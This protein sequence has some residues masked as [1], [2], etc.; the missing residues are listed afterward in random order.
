MYV[1]LCKGQEGEGEGE[2]EG[3]KKPE[4]KGRRGEGSGRREGREWSKEEKEGTTE[5][6]RRE[7]GGR[8]LWSRD[9][10]APNVQQNYPLLH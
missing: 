8:N 9:R 3:R 10:S 4:G 1:Y 6:E 7:K 5:G 2:R